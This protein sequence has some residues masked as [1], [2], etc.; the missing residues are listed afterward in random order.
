MRMII[1]SIKYHNIRRMSDLTIDFTKDGQLIG[2]TFVMM[3]NG[4]GKTTTIELLKG[5]L[6]GEAANWNSKKV[7]EYRHKDE[8][9]GSFEIM[10]EFDGRPYAYI[11]QMD[12]E[13]GTAKI[14]TSC[15]PR[16]LDIGVRYPDS[17]SRIFSKEFVERFIFDGEQPSKALD[18]QSSEA[19]DMI[20]YLYRL[21][22]LDQIKT[23]NRL[24]L[25]SIQQ[26]SSE[27]VKSVGSKQAIKNW[28]TKKNDAAENLFR[29]E[30]ERDKLI[31]DRDILDIAIN[32]LKKKTDD[33]LDRF[34]ELSDQKEKTLSSLMTVQSNIR[35]KNNEILERLKQPE[36]VKN[37]ICNDMRCLGESMQKLKLPSNTSKDF[38]IELSQQDECI[39]GRSIGDNE[40]TA[41][42]SNAKRYLGD[43][44]QGVMNVVKNALLNSQY[45][46]CL[47]ENVGLLDE[48]VLKE[49]RLQEELTIIQDKF[50]KKGGSEAETL[51]EEYESKKNAR[52]GLQ[53][54]IDILEDTDED[55][56]MY[57]TTNNIPKAKL[58]YLE[59]E[60]N[61][62]EVTKT[63]EAYLK[64]KAVDS[65]LDNIKI[66]ATNRL[67]EVIIAKTNEKLQEVI[68]DDVVEIE[69]IDGNIKLK[70]KGG[71]SA[72]QELGIAYCFLGT[73]FEDSELEFP[74][75]IDSP[76]GSLDFVRR[77]AIAKMIP[78]LFKQM[79]AFVTSSEVEEF[80]DHFYSDNDAQFITIE[81]DDGEVNIHH[82]V[83]YFDNYQK[84]HR[85]ENN[86]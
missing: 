5:V 82:D 35:E 84:E 57:N 40:R 52:I 60:K 50:E 51:R 31:E 69:G 1:K 25:E 65:M 29:L 61:Y 81:A 3:G 10:T 18:D 55:N 73:L 41:I 80:A 86:G 13:Q 83:E 15:P 11:L 8:A 75:V 46:E 72:G 67:K 71:A 44:Q 68:K 76:A 63:H 38:F 12:Y 39:C 17:I 22:E 20:K 33:L 70:R 30:K 53:E 45:D 54:R 79:V 78:N 36:K 85:E 14:S 47:K 28:E 42:R 2:K 6:S 9:E 43:D 74:F 64:C 21:D 59:K 24:L 77:A 19:D 66:T 32:E 7:K 4:T 26:G 49:R 23:T 56:P 34:V 48:E 62:A 16:G 37:T 58:D 27:G